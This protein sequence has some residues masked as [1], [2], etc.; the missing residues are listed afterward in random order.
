MEGRW[1]CRPATPTDTLDQ[2]FL[3]PETGRGT[4][5]FD[6]EDD[7]DGDADFDRLD[8]PL[9]E[10]ADLVIIYEASGRGVLE[11]RESFGANNYFY[12]QR[13]V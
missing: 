13:V 10:D 11:G 9:L 7:F 2:G 5:F 12:Q 6:G 1:P 4:T 3:G 8:G